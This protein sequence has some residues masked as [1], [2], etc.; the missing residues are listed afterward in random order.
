M[1]EVDGFTVLKHLKKN[2]NTQHIPVVVISAK[3]LTPEEKKLL[4]GNIASHWQKGSFSTHHLLTELIA[5]IKTPRDPETADVIDALQAIDKS[6]YKVVV[7]DD[8]PDDIRVLRRILE[9]QRK[10]EISE[11]QNGFI[12]LDLIRYEEPDLVILDLT[13]PDMDGFDVIGAMKTDP[14]LSQIPIIILTG[15][16][17]SLAQRR[18]LDQ[19]ELLVMQKGEITMEKLVSEVD[20]KLS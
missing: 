20:S 3:E 2:P 16:E 14:K 13:M 4:Q 9:S 5:T 12:G 15:T 7:I 10:Y 17:L 1:P 19:D 8:N 11:A 18:Q 6:T